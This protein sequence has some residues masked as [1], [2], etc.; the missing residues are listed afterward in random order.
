MGFEPAIT[1]S[2]RPHTHALD[3][4]AVGIASIVGNYHQIEHQASDLSL[5]L[6]AAIFRSTVQAYKSFRARQMSTVKEEE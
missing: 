6:C 1:A 3:R 2:K 5:L 4:A